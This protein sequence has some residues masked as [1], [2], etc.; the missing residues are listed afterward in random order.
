MDKKGKGNFRQRMQEKLTPTILQ[1]LHNAEI[2]IEDRLD[3]VILLMRA[4]GLPL[5]QS[6]EKTIRKRFADCV[7]AQQKQKRNRKKT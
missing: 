1:M 3:G 7:A 5:E 4:H 2:P 6:R